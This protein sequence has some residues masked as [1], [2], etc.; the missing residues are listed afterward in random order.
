MK[1]LFLLERSSLKENFSLKFCQFLL[2]KF[3]GVQDHISEN[4]LPGECDRLITRNCY[5]TLN[6]MADHLLVLEECTV[7]SFW[8]ICETYWC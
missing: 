7:R 3:S 1:L 4:I 6:Y 5:L 2:G 8:T